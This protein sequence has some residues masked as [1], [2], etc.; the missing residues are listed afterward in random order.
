MKTESI[1]ALFQTACLF[2]LLLFAPS[3]VTTDA[4]PTVK[5]VKISPRLSESKIREEI[6]KYTPIGCSSTNVLEFAR[7]RLKHVAAPYEDGPATRRG[8]RG[9]DVS[10]GVR[11]VKVCL[12]EYGFPGR[13]GTFISWAFDENNKLID[14]I[15]EKWRDSL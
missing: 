2:G 12:G 8:L 1:S 5:D 13:T 9:P 15:V 10:V 3:C 7:T 6:L 14:V 4:S 11:S